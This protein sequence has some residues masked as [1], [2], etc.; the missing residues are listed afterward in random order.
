VRRGLY[1][2]HALTFTLARSR[3]Y[4]FPSAYIPYHEFRT[5]EKLGYMYPM[6][7]CLVQGSGIRPW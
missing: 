6:L 7:T 1:V 5:A 2:L 3:S 4:V